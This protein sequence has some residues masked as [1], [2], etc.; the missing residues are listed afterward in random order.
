MKNSNVRMSLDLSYYNDAV[1]SIFGDSCKDVAYTFCPDVDLYVNTK[2]SVD[3]IVFSNEDGIKYS[4]YYNMYSK[5]EFGDQTKVL[6]SEVT[7]CTITTP[8]ELDSE[9]NRTKMGITY[10]F[11]RVITP[12]KNDVG[13]DFIITKSD[14]MR[15]IIKEIDRRKGISNISEEELPKLIGFDVK[16]LERKVMDILINDDFRKFCNKHNISSKKAFILYGEPGCFTGDTEV[17][18]LNRG[19]VSLKELYESNARDIPVYSMD[20]NNELRVSKA[21]HCQLTKYTN[22]LVEIEIDGVVA[23]RCTPDHLWKLNSGEWVEA[24][25]LEIGS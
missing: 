14:E 15:E 8:D 5:D 17:M 11:I 1:I 4:C 19:K 23:K 3:N 9:G 7:E 13:Y 16:E 2:K 18:T 10:K 20:D 25:D 22:E 6:T 12:F 24:K 21:S